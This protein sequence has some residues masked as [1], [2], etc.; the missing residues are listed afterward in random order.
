MG[1]KNRQ[2]G[3]KTAPP[4]KKKRVVETTRESHEKNSITATDN[5]DPGMSC[6]SI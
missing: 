5:N 3:P 6:S 1:S 4:Y 2:N